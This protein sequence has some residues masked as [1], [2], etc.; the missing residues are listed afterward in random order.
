MTEAQILADFRY[1]TLEDIQAC[2]A[3]AADREPGRDS[4][5]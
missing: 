2:Y 1:L 4:A 3:F 5:Q